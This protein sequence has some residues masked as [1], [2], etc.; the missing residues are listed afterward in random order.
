MS[1][2][3]GQQGK[4]LEQPQ[5]K[6]RRWPVIKAKA[7]GM[8]MLEISGIDQSFPFM[9]RLSRGRRPGNGSAWR[10]QPGQRD[11]DEPVDRGL[12]RQAAGRCEG[13]EAIGRKLAGRDIIPEAA[14][15][16]ALGE[17][18]SDEIAELLLR[19]GDVLTSMQARREF[20]AVVL[21]GNERVGLKHSF[22]PLASIAS[23]VADCYKIFKVAADLTFVPGHENRFDVWEVLVKRRTTYAG[24]LGNLRHRHRQQPVF[25]H[26]RCSGVQGRLAHRA[27]MRVD[28]FV[29]K[30]W[31]HPKIPDAA[32]MSR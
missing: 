3:P 18:V 17:Q 1:S 2:D 21:V 24:L 13:V 19:P 31:H 23:L 29:P 26:Q 9:V 15:L 12:G 20:G 16:C 4:I 25:G 27:A 28:R 5:R 7:A 22:E 11:L 32:T 10:P 14:S 6:H 8:L 30:L